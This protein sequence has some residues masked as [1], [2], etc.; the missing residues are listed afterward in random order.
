MSTPGPA[1]AL[2]Y[3]PNWTT[4]ERGPRR[5][6]WVQI[7]KPWA[8]EFWN[9]YKFTRGS[10]VLNRTV[11][12]RNTPQLGGPVPVFVGSLFRLATSAVCFRLAARVFNR[13]FGLLS[14]VS[15]P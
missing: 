8:V 5:R 13:R 7:E 14:R 12:I 3:A 11:V 10:G 2:K 9:N 1:A 15:L 4:R 6:G